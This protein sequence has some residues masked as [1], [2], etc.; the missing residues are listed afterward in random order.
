MISIMLFLEASSDKESTLRH[1][2]VNLKLSPLGSG[3]TVVLTG[4]Q[5][6]HQKRQNLIGPSEM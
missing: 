5:V 3:R 2:V 4:S 6:Y 1:L